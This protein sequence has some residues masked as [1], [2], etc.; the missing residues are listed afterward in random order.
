MGDGTGRW[1]GYGGRDMDMKS[2]IWA[3]VQVYGQPDAILGDVQR[4]MACS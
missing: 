3:I 2:V 4:V 1:E